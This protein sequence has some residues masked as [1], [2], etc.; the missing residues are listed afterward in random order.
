MRIFLVQS[1][2]RLFLK[3]FFKIRQNLKEEFFIEKIKALIFLESILVI[4]KVEKLQ[5]NIEVYDNLSILKFD[6]SL[7]IGF[8]PF[9]H[10]YHLELIRQSNKT[11]CV[12][13][14][15]KLLSQFLHQ[16][17]DSRIRFKF[18]S[19]LWRLLREYRKR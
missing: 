11:I 3:D 8:R 2:E 9:L 10:Q 15:F 14:S 18:R 5:S 1:Y 19:Q 17:R 16:L 7:K 12:F 6:F 4:E 13:S